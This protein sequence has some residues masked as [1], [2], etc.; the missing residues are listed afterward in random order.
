VFFAFIFLSRGE[1]TLISI[2]H[3]LSNLF[4]TINSK[5]NPRKYLSAIGDRILTAP[6]KIGRIITLP[7]T[8]VAMI[9]FDHVLAING[10]MI[11]NGSFNDNTNYVSMNNFEWDGSHEYWKPKFTFGD[12]YVK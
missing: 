6:Q 2:T 11:A 1:S 7:E 12:K 10:S 4:L 8:D 5:E 3:F 9:Q